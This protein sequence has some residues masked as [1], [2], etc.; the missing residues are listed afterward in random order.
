MRVKL[1]IIASLLASLLGSGLA[2]LIAW[3]L[4]LTP[5]AVFALLATTA[6]ACIFV[7]RHT[8]RRRA[9]QAMLTALFTT[10]FVLLIIYAVHHYAQTGIK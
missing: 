9:L 10:V 2:V 4:A 8:A 5:L 3:T 7:Y 1:L 6:A